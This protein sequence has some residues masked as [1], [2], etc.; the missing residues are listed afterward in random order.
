[1][2]T[3]VETD[4]MQEALSLIENAYHQLEADCDRVYSSLKFDIRKNGENRLEGKI[5]SIEEKIGQVKK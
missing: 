5:K 1:M 3:I 2:G 4:S